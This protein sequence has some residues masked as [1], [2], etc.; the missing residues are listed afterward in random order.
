[1]RWG[2]SR[3]LFLISPKHCHTGLW[4]ACRDNAYTWRRCKPENGTELAGGKEAQQIDQ[5]LNLITS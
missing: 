4:E 5:A 1:L 3:E 2:V